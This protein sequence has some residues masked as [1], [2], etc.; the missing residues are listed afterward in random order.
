[1]LKCMIPRKRLAVLPESFNNPTAR[2]YSPP[3][4]VR[5]ALGDEFPLMVDANQQWIAE[6]A[7]RMGRKWNSSILFD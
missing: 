7:I 1:M 3:T 6:T 5:E 2:G 4:A